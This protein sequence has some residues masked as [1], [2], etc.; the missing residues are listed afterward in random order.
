MTLEEVLAVLRAN[1]G[2]AVVIVGGPSSGKSH[3]AHR[4]DPDGTRTRCTDE[5]VGVLEWSEA[6]AEVAR[7]LDEPGDWVIEG[8]ATA[9][10]L[11]KWLR[12]SERRAGI[13]VLMAQTF[14][15]LSKGQAAMAKGVATV[16]KEIALALLIRGAEVLKCDGVP[17]AKA[18]DAGVAGA[19]SS[20]RSPEAAAQ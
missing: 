17:S 16:W 12:S 14:G 7:W 11:R 2:R 5:L 1:P 15:E 13:V 18:A 3:L 6:S 19:S 8:V 4:L 9:R 10:A 20:S